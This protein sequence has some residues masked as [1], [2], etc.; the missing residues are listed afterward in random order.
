MELISHWIDEN[1]RD[2]F[3]PD[4]LIEKL[5]CIDSKDAENI[6]ILYFSE[7]NLK[8]KIAISE[9]IIRLLSATINI[10]IQNIKTYKKEETK[11]NGSG[12]VYLAKTDTENI[13]KIGATKD[14]T[15]REKTLRVGNVFL[16]IFAS[17]TSANM[18]KTERLFHKIFSSK[19]IGGEWFLLGKDDIDY[20]FESLGFTR[21]LNAGKDL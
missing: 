20:L 8:E 16:S 9:A 17:T 10:D 14:L 1:G 15:K 21:F 5:T 6:R 12:F 4:A 11:K 7:G 3:S 13:Y 19:N 2:C 18:F